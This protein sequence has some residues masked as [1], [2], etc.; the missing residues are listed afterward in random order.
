MLSP[1]RGFPPQLGHRHVGYLPELAAE[2]AG[3]GVAVLVVPR[4]EDG[5]DVVTIARTPGDQ[6][7]DDDVLGGKD[8]VDGALER[9]VLVLDDGDEDI[10]SP[11]PRTTSRWGSSPDSATGVTA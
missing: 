9:H 7:V 2:L 5:G 11:R 8:M 10:D 3:E 4:V 1:R 6:L